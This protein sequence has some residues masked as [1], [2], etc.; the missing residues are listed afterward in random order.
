MKLV[1]GV[2]RIFQQGVLRF[3]SECDDTHLKNLHGGGGGG[4]RGNPN[5]FFPFQVS[6]FHIRGRGIS[7]YSSDKQARKKGEGPIFGPR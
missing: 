5:K 6:I 7:L 3:D 2:C 1:R 4:G